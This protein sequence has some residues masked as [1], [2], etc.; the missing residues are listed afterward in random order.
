[1]QSR[2]GEWLNGQAGSCTKKVVCLQ[3]IDDPTA[4]FLKLP[5]RIPISSIGVGE[6]LDIWNESPLRAAARQQKCRFCAAHPHGAGT[7]AAAEP[8]CLSC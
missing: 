4:S 8:R 1:M 6:K 5:S 2:G 3:V 7:A